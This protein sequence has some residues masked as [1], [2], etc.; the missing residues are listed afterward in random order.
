MRMRETL[1]SAVITIVILAASIGL[2]TKWCGT[3]FNLPDKAWE[4]MVTFHTDKYPYSMRLLTTPTVIGLSDVTGL[5]LRISFGLLQFSLMFGLGL[6]FYRL[7]RHL[8]IRPFWS[9]FGLASLLLCLPVF[10]AI[11]EPIHTWDDIWGYLFLTLCVSA[12]VRRHFFPAGL[13][14]IATCF[15]R[16]QT[17]IYFPA[18]AA[19]VIYLSD[20]TQ[21]I[22]TAAAVIAPLLLFGV[23]LAS[24][25]QPMES[26]RYQLILFNFDGFLRTRDS[27]YSIFMAFGWLWLGMMFALRGKPPAGVKFE[28]HRLLKTGT[29]YAVPI[30]LVFA[31]GFTLVRETR[32]LFP[33]AVLVVPLVMIYLQEKSHS[34]SGSLRKNGFLWTLALVSLALLGLG[35]WMGH[36][37]FPSFEYR[38]CPDFSR[39]WAGVQIG[40]ALVLV[41]MLVAGRLARRALREAK[42]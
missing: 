13:W 17:L 2:H 30:T 7:L 8:G 1:I 19:G 38:Q 21:K 3:P 29:L 9:A 15:A 25:W 16:E 34:L 14:F 11:S 32:I 24:V 35:I 4:E 6:A 26:G 36:L 27:I 42:V 31:C 5:P 37:I 40:L 23:Y 33:P 28:Y 39:L 12:I 22:R 18:Y 10:F 20:Q 41:W